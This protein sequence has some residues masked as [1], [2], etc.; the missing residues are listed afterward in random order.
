MTEL[1]SLYL[2]ASTHSLLVLRTQYRVSRRITS[3]HVATLK[4][5]KIASLGGNDQEDQE[6]Q[7]EEGKHRCSFYPHAGE[8]AL[9]EPYWSFGHSTE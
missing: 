5:D 7:E 2:V 4:L 6:G 9:Q 3:E 8:G 1:Q